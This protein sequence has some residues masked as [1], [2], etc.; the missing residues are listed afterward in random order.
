MEVKTHS[1]NALMVS[2]AV[3]RAPPVVR[4]WLFALLARGEKASST[5]EG[6]ARTAI[7][8]VLSKD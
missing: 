4:G 2:N 7:R 8:K 5:K 6:T 1:V 3:V